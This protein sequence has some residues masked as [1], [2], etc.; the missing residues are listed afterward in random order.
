MN[1]PLDPVPAVLFDPGR[2]PPSPV[3]A[4][5]LRLLLAAFL[6]VES[7]TAAEAGRRH[8]ENDRK[9][10]PSPMVYGLARTVVVGGE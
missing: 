5:L 6:V 8:A 10:S 4:I 7:A 1:P 3:N 2:F 9:R